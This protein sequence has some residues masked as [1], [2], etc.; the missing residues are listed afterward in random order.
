MASRDQFFVREKQLAPLAPASRLLDPSPPSPCLSLELAQFGVD[1]W[2]IDHL[3]SPAEC[4]RIV[5][6][7]T[8]TGFSFWD[9]EGRCDA[10]TYLRTCDT[11]EFDG[12]DLCDEIWRRLKPFL[13]EQSKLNES[14]ERWQ[15]DLN[16]NWE[17]RGLNTHLLVN[18][19]MSGGHF[20]PHADGSVQLSFDRRSLYTVLIYLNDCDDGGQTQLIKGEQSASTVEVDS[21]GVAKPETVVYAVK[22]QTGRC[23]VYWHQTLHAGAPVGE[24]VTKFTMRTDV[25]YE[26]N[27]AACVTPEDHEAYELIR[28]AATLE[29]SGQ[30][31]EAL[32]LLQ[33]AAKM[34]AVIAKAYRLS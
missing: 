28:R 2:V 5:R 24:K 18:R 4:G 3:L 19:Y 27:P 34:S 22:P 13:P 1:G 32:P 10:S 9:P 31:M 17:S 16:G 15:H 12:E 7:C 20:A 8:A 29:A 11:L 26:R 23:L 25:M 6:A 30:A 21:K 33:Q 14:D